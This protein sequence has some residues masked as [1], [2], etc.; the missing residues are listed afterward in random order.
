MGEYIFSG[1]LLMTLF[2][3]AAKNYFYW[4][5]YENTAKYYIFSGI[6]IEVRL[7]IVL[8]VALF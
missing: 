1:T 2:K 4:H 8:L 3:S 7:K 6:L 5:F